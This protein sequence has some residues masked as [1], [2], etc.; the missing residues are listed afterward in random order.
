MDPSLVRGAHASANGSRV[1]PA[2]D[3]PRFGGGG[4]SGGHNTLHGRHP[5]AGGAAQAIRS[6][7]RTDGVD[8]RSSLLNQF[9]KAPL[10]RFQSEQHLQSVTLTAVVPWILFSLDLVAVALVPQRTLAWLV[11]FGLFFVCILFFLVY[12]QSGVKFYLHLAAWGFLAVLIAAVLG[13]RIFDRS[14]SLYWMSRNRVFH[15][16]VDPGQVSFAYT[17]SN[18]LSFKEGTKIDLRRVFGR[19]TL[20]TDGSTFCVAPVMDR[21]LAELGKVHFWAAGRDCCEPLSGF[22]CGHALRPGVRSGALLSPGMGAGS[23]FAEWE[24]EHFNLA[25][26]QAAKI[27][28]L[29]TEEKPVF[30]YWHEVPEDILIDRLDKAVAYVGASSLLYLM[31][32][33]FVAGLV[34]FV[35]VPNRL[36]GG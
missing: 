8:E 3:L 13:D 5:A 29:A 11:H 22:M 30:L 27:Y 12:R 14:T 19:R 20:E 7:F 36:I 33:F 26:Q 17:D 28:H 9:Q 15:H 25:A 1:P 34:Y 6:P 32:S 24:Y 18:A 16:E 4:G 2:D 21:A 23:R 10:R 35:L 31:F